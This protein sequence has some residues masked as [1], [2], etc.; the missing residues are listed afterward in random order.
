[1]KIMVALITK[2]EEIYFLVNFANIV[3]N[4]IVDNQAV[5]S[6]LEVI[7]CREPLPAAR[8]FALER[9]FASVL[10]HVNFQLRFA[11][12]LF[13]TRLADNL[14]LGFFTLLRS[15]GQDTCSER[16]DLLLSN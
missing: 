16:F 4:V 8:D 12:H 1:M 15:L 11:R 6:L 5:N 10:H 2:Y 9:R 13:A 3:D 14:L 7:F